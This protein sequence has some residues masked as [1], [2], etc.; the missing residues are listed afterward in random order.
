MAVAGAL[1]AARLRYLRLGGRDRE[2][3]QWL[4]AGL[5]LAA[6]AALVSGVLHLLVGWPGAVAAVADRGHGGGARPG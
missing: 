5:V 1:P 3:M 6:D 4:G 2:R